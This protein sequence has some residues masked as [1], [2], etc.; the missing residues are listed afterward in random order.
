M[1]KLSF[2][3][4]N[5]P[6]GLAPE[7]ES[8]VPGSF[9]NDKPTPIPFPPAPPYPRP[10]TPP[11]P[12]HL[13]THSESPSS[14]PSLVLPKQ[15]SMKIEEVEDNE[16]NDT[17][18]L[19]PSPPPPPEAGPSHP[20][21]G[22][23]ATPQRYGLRC[24]RPTTSSSGAKAEGTQERKERE[25]HYSQIGMINENS[26]RVLLVFSTY[27]YKRS[28]RFHMQLGTLILS[29]FPMSIW[30]HVYLLYIHVFP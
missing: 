14:S 13:P 8:S 12:P 1:S 21:P 6:R 11:V 19:S 27:L 25:E 26:T 5:T 17:K 2:Q 16:D 3:R 10:P 22:E 30:Y 7:I 15:P 24:Q 4:E 20:Q 28:T 23:D 9:G 29:V 18:M